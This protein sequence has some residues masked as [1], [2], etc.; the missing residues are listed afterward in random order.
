LIVEAFKQV[1]VAPTQ[2]QKAIDCLQ[3]RDRSLIGAREKKYLRENTRG[4]LPRNGMGG[5]AEERILRPP[6]GAKEK[7][8]RSSP[9]T[10]LQWWRKLGGNESK[11]LKTATD[12]TPFIASFYTF[13]QAPLHWYI[14]DWL[15]KW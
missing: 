4:L 9:Q 5:F 7:E 12:K 13:K 3:I 14:K 8:K 15:L 1:F 11:I 10:Y 6:R 2:K